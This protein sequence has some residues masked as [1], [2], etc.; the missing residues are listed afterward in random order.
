MGGVTR[1]QWHAD[2][3]LARRTGPDG[4]T[5]SW[6]YDGEGNCLTHTDA[7][8]GVSRFE[9]THFDLL[10][11]RTGPDGARYEF[12]HDASLRLRRVT[13]P[14]GLTWI[15]EYDA[16][17]HVVRET[18][19]DGRAV[20]YRYDAAGQLTARV[21]TL[22]GTVS[23]ERDQ[24][25]QVVRKDADGRVT[26]YAYDRTGR[27]L[28]ATGPDSDLRYQ[29]DRRGSVKTELVDGRALTYAY[30]ALGRRKRRTTPTGHVTTYTY[31]ADGTPHRLTTGHHH[32]A[33]THDAAGRELTR[34]LGDAITVTS[35][36][37]EAGR[38][39]GQH[40]TAQARVVNSRSYAYRADGH[41]LS[42]TDRLS[43]T[44]TFDL[45]P[46][47]RVTAVHAHG[48]TERYA[49]DASGNQ[50][51]ASWPSRHPG[52]EATGPRAYTGIT[53]TRAGGVRFEHDAL[54]RVILR[55]KTRLSRKPDTWR[56]EWDTEDRL[57]AVTTPD[58]TRWRYRYDPLGRRIAKQRLA[59]DSDSVVEE[60]RFTW[61]GAILCEQTSNQ[62][63]VPHTVAL[64]W[65]HRADVL[66]SQTERILTADDRQEEIDRRF[67]AIATDLIGTPT[68]LID[69]AG[70]VAWRSRATLWGATAWARDSSA[71]TPLR[72]PGQYYD[73]ETGLHYNY[74]RHYDPETGR[75]TSQDPL[76]LGP[77][78]NP[79]AYV[80]N[81]YSWTDPLG[82]A[83][84]PR[85][86]WADKAD[87]SSQKVMSKKFHA[88]AGDFL[89]SPG[90]LNKAN[91]QRFEEAMREHMTAE[92]T[93]IYRF[94]YRN[95]GPAVG[96]IDPTS[97][98]MV[99][100]HADG[101]F[102]SA[103]KLGDKQFQG[104]IDKGFLW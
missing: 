61:D 98:K 28:E 39:T 48:W 1:L 89:D 24:L 33:F 77:A 104:I 46:V 65:D 6:T 30:D 53:L 82:L 47:G 17:D 84:C 88:H 59:A 38:L 78:P 50:T 99:M 54:G 102:W 16:A 85:G 55:Q 62:Q 29:Y 5:E 23:F 73:P 90:N 9:Y 45:D 58:G 93:K 2:G 60:V 69:E 103:W 49:Y 63:D 15:Y 3:Q 27:L 87:F 57:T 25:G 64:T 96:F 41:L 13:N 86:A 43:G 11:A 34:V 26:T 20:T 70:G 7:V 4:A 80:D 67:F 91:L 97:Q 95:Q 44:R 8:G 83:P 66:L 40:I 71:Y 79:A 94:D 92:G 36:W 74:F 51:S 22:G 21:D 72:F 68:E 42:V 37:D 75:Y 18:D 32:V 56:Y 81:P 52:H 10:A 76:G 31:S 19:F 35:A 14:H 12:E 100:L 101:R